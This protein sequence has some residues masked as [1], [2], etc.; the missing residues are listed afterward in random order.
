[1]VIR[2][3]RTRWNYTHAMI[4]RALILRKAVDDWVFQHETLRPLMLSNSEW[5]LLE[6]LASV[7]EVRAQTK[8]LYTSN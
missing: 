6:Q 1:M 4:K 2:D 7:L 3:V 5:T 8:L